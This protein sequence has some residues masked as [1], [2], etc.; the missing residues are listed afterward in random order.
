[1]KITL[2][3]EESIRL[4]PTPGAM[5]IEAPSAEQTYSPFHMLAS[6]L[7]YCTFSVFYAWA[8]QTKLDASGLTIDVGWTFADDPHRVACYDLRF[9]WPGLPPNRLDAARRVAELCTVH[10]TFVH[11]PTVSVDGT[12]GGAAAGG[13]HAQADGADA[14][15]VPAPSAAP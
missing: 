5:T 6:G 4:E 2:L 9:E 3:S 14:P 7:A 12:I 10:A 11:P 1:M 15:I 13:P 8:K